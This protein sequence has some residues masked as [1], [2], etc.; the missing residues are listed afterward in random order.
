[1]KP[2]NDMYRKG[3]NEHG[4]TPEQEIARVRKDSYWFGVLCGIIGLVFL[5]GLSGIFKEFPLEVATGI[6][7]VLAIVGIAWFVCWAWKKGA[8]NAII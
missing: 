5:V 2:T 6:L 8:S 7:G 4:E 3:V 1:M